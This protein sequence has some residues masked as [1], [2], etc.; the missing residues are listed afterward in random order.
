[1]FRLGFIG[2]VGEASTTD[3]LLEQNLPNP[4]SETTTIH[5]ELSSSAYV[6]LK[7]FDAQGREVA[8]LKNAR[9]APGTKA[10]LF[11]VSGLGTGVYSYCL[12]ADGH[13]ATKRMV[14]VR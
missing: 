14:V 9:E 10:V 12:S 11:D 5:Y 4:C 6:S 13:T 7:V 2:S 1:M 8:V 3:A